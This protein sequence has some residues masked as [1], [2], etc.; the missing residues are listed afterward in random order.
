MLYS[1]YFLCK[2]Q[3]KWI[4]IL[5]I[6]S[7]LLTVYCYTKVLHFWSFF[8]LF[9]NCHSI[10]Y[11][12]LH[13]LFNLLLICIFERTVNIVF[14]CCNYYNF[15]KY[16]SMNFS[17]CGSYGYVMMIIK[18]SHFLHYV[19]NGHHHPENHHCSSVHSWVSAITVCRNSDLA[20]SGA[21][22]GSVRLWAIGS[23]TKDITS[24][25][26]IPLVSKRDSN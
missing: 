9:W 6:F 19:E 4:F 14:C 18:W 12:N 2:L 23:E 26:D 25:Y 11:M 7:V 5:I 13:S 24:L 10:S 15:Y 20:A 22:N 17:A 8:L 16:E 3:V 21:G 1:Y